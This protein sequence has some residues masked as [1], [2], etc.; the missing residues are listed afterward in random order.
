MITKAF[1]TQRPD[2][3][4][5]MRL[6]SGDADLWMRKNI[7]ETV[8]SETGVVSYEAD[9]VYMLTSAT[10]QEIAADFNA[11]YNTA[12][13]WQ[14]PTPQKPPTEGERIAALEAENERLKEALGSTMEA[15]DFILFGI[16]EGV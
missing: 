6:P 13:S 9:E 14:A 16:D 7:T 5:Y 15:V 12:A 2:S 1:Y 8:D 3:I 4:K 10:E 11:W